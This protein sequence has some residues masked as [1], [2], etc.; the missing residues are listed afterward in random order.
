MNTAKI[1]TVLEDRSRLTLVFHRGAD[2]KITKR[3]PFFENPII[4]ES[5]RANYVK[6][7][8]LGRAG[9][10]YTYTGAESRSFKV[11]FNLTHP[12]I[13]SMMGAEY[14]KAFGSAAS[15]SKDEKKDAFLPE[16]RYTFDV[17]S[18]TDHSPEFGAVHYDDRYNKLVGL[19]ARPGGIPP[20]TGLDTL[21]ATRN[22][23]GIDVINYWVNLLRS[24]VLNDATNTLNGPPIVRLTHGILYRNLPCIC[25]DV[26]ISHNEI[27]GYDN[28]TLL[29]RVIVISLSLEEIRMGD[30]GKFELDPSDLTLIS[31][32]NLAGWE[33]V[34]DSP[35][36]LDPQEDLVM[37]DRRT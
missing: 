26:N 21:A 36:T 2:P 13:E 17:G 16:G 25:T 6:Y 33:S 5:Q 4:Q 7:Q 32:D 20:L 30:L 24:T 27:A 22:T 3:V 1:N 14:Y 18:T 15:L 35:Y 12:H 28:K 11:N 9:S 34:V 37:L 8:P 29:P 23:K 19:D 31:R 10:M